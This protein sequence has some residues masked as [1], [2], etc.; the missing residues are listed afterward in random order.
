MLR[1]YI[2]VL[3]W[4]GIQET[5]QFFQVAL[6]VIPDGTGNDSFSQARPCQLDVAHVCQIFRQFRTYLRLVSSDNR[7]APLLFN[8]HRK[9]ET[10]IN[11]CLGRFAC[12]LFVFDFPL[13]MKRLKQLV[14]FSRVYTPVMVLAYPLP[15]SQHRF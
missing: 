12:I 10:T 14:H 8:R 7:T 5:I 13:T 1:R 2:F 9:T 4:P 6:R 3:T 15:G 11:H